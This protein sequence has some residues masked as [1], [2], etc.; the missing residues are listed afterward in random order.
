MED[1]KITKRYLKHSA[2]R[3]LVLLILA[4]ATM[5]LAAIFSSVFAA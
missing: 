2:T 3:L 4:A 1:T 5:G